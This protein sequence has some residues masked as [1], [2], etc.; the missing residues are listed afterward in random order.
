LREFR[1]LEDADVYNQ[2][3]GDLSEVEGENIRLGDRT[4][5]G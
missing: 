5:E 2:G 4:S 1:I 3:M